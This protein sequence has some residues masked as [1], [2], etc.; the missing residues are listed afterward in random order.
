MKRLKTLLLGLGAVGLAF[1]ANAAGGA[2]HAHA[3]E[4]GWPFASVPA[5]QLEKESVQRGY[6]VYR[7][8]CASCHSMELLSYRI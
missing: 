2:K 1:S 8:V 5:G 6:Q 3:P 4:G 7:E